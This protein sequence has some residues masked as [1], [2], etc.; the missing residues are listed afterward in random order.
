MVSSVPLW[1]PNLADGAARASGFAGA[2]LQRSE[3]GWNRLAGVSG[4]S[5]MRGGNKR[6][7]E[8]QAYLGL[9]R[10][11]DESGREGLDIF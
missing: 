11:I 5:A 8:G 4:G 9:A 1:T 3:D 10:R 6:E 7:V 2:P